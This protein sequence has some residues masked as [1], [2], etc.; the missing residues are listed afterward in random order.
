MTETATTVELGGRAVVMTYSG[1]AAEYEAMH[2]R[3]IVVDRSH[4]DRMRFAGNKSADALNGLVTNDVTALGAGQGMYAAALTAKGKVVADLR[5]LRL[6][7]DYLVDVSARAREGW[8]SLVR[9][10]VNPR[11]AA[12]TDVTASS[13]VVGVFGTQARYVVEEVTGLGHS[14]LGILLPYHHVT[15]QHDGVEMRVMR[16]PDLGVEGYEIFVLPE[17]FETVWELSTKAHATPAGIA[18]CDVAR[19]E[20]GRPEWGVDM[21]DNTIPQEANL[22]DLGAI[23]YTKGCYT[24]QEVVARVHFRGHVNRTLRGLRAAGTV[25]PPQRATLLDVEGKVVG[26]VRSS[27]T[28]PRLGG[29]AL[30]MVRREIE[31]GAPLTARWTVETGSQRAGEAG[32][33]GDAE[34]AGAAGEAQVDVVALPF[35]SP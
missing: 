29:I 28:S 21:D 30:A 34:T 14:A 18:V 32:E 16:S 20:A 25:P 7:T 5:I 12:Y 24:G 9:K 8:T 1:I 27:L 26:E 11:L 31:N 6:E 17:A 19:V 23:S 15:V 22:E 4:R 10:Y 35:P 2:R 13:R 33:A 3:A